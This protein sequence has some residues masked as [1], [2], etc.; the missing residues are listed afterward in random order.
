MIISRIT[1]GRQTAG[2]H[3]VR[4]S[5]M[6]PILHIPGSPVSSITAMEARDAEHGSHNPRSITLTPLFKMLG[7]DISVTVTT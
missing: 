7:P 3:G 2:S 1:A 6:T 5:S 4:P